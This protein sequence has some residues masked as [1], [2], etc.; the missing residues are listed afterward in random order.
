MGSVKI[1]IPNQM[2]L[3]MIW[4]ENEVPLGFLTPDGTD[5]AALKR[6]RTVD[7]WV[8]SNQRHR[9][10]IP[11]DKTTI[12]NEL[13]SGFKLSNS[14]RRWTTQNV[15]WRV[16]DP[17]GFEIEIS[18]ENLMT[19][20]SDTAIIRGEILGRLIYGRTTGSNVLL[21]ENSE[22]YTD[23]VKMTEV[24]SSVISIRDIKPGYEVSLHNGM[25]LQYFG[26]YHT[27]SCT[28]S[29]TPAGDTGHEK[30]IIYIS[31]KKTHVFLDKNKNKFIIIGS[32]K[33]GKIINKSI[34]LTPNQAI[35]QISNMMMTEFYDIDS[36]G[37][38]SYYDVIGFTPSN[39]ATLSFSYEPVTIEHVEEIY[40]KF[41]K[42]G[43]YRY[44]NLYAL[45][46][47]KTYTCSYYQDTFGI[48]GK[49][50]ADVPRWDE[51]VIDDQALT[52]T[53]ITDDVKL[54]SFYR[55]NSYHIRK[56]VA[57]SE[58]ADTIKSINFMKIV[59]DTGE[60]TVGFYIH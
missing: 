54:N 58:I 44:N 30:D 17:R 8:S 24:V 34:E 14:N 33:I 16:I 46:D 26:Y 27:I 18:S 4:R 53:Y 3:G 29:K 9:S 43:N 2:Y 36:A 22:E 7:N 50:N 37:V 19:L 5:S 6:K 38:Y 21:H 31:D 1:T 20:M 41:N 45:S 47:N 59:V 49:K 55:R 56:K 13:L 12:K 11:I 25:E 42:L 35:A 32:P 60:V 39:K 40:K 51:T 52:Y 48:N 28:A 15:V 57:W 10:K 23:A